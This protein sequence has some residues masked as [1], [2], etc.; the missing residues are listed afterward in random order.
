MELKIGENILIT[1]TN[2]GIGLGFVEQL[3]DVPGV[4]RIFATCRN[5]TQAYKLLELQKN[6]PSLHLIKLDVQNDASIDNAFS[7]IEKLLEGDAL[8]VLINNAG[9]GE[10]EGT[11]IDHPNRE[12]FASHFDVNTTAAVLIGAKFMPLFPK[13]ANKAQPALLINI[14]SLVASLTYCPFIPT[15][16]IAYSL[17]KAAL[18]HYTRLT[19]KYLAN[20]GVIVISIHPGRV[21][22]DL[23]GHYG[24]ITVEESVISML[25]IIKDLSQEDSGRFI[26]LHGKDIPF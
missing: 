23:S 10:M 13:P 5:P 15:K 1:G 16:Q 4:K 20:Q 21:K 18:N 6:Y 22:T 8:N 17:S 26:D 24:E 14:S 12:S 2:R 25:K 7:E 19:S 9:I 3:V 11:T